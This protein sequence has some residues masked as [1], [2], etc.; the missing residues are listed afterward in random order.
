MSSA[1][2]V[3][4]PLARP[5]SCH[6]AGQRGQ[7]DRLERRAAPRR[8]SAP[9]RDARAAR[10]AEYPCDSSRKVDRDDPLVV[11]SG[12]RRGDAIERA[13][14]SARD[15]QQHAAR[16][17]P[18]PRSGTA[19]APWATTPTGDLRAGARPNNTG[20]DQG[21]NTAKAATLQSRRGSSHRRAPVIFMSHRA[22]GVRQE[23]GGGA[24]RGR[25]ETFRDSLPYQPGRAGSDRRANSRFP[26]RA[27]RRAPAAGRRGFAHAAARI[28]QDQCAQPFAMARGAS[29]DGGA[30][31][32]RPVPPPR[33]ARPPGAAS[34]VSS[35]QIVVAG[36]LLAQP[37][38]S[39]RNLPPSTPRPGRTS[40]RLCPTLSRPPLRARSPPA[41]VAARTNAGWL[42]IGSQTSGSSKVRP[43]RT[44]AWRPRDR[45][46]LPIQDQGLSINCGSHTKAA[47]PEPV[48]DHRHGLGGRRV[49]YRATTGG[50]VAP[51][52]PSSA[53]KVFG[54]EVASSGGV[55]SSNPGVSRCTA[56]TAVQRSEDW[57]G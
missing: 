30:P 55:S 34:A 52:W 49:R 5:P 27:P 18:A 1:A 42:A 53:K 12:G 7:A 22:R 54:H 11:E 21:R 50:Q 3:R 31:V 39:A 38:T 41:T 9:C 37:A 4:G 40:P 48:T 44:L 46:R 47:L 26:D 51:P 19:A 29:L 23:P 36:M 10:P 15:D 20:R 28:K 14:R 6:R 25:D 35:A 13:H 43:R 16:R 17:A 32:P 45:H 33:L 56:R 24:E 8:R 2:A 57:S